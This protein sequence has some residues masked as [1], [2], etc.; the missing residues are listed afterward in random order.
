LSVLELVREF[1]AIETEL[2]V[3]QTPIEVAMDEWALGTVAH[4][5][6]RTRLRPLAGADGPPRAR[7]RRR[8]APADDLVAATERGSASPKRVSL[9]STRPGRGVQTVTWLLVACAVG[10]IALGVTAI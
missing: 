3:A 8:P 2:G 10:V 1:Q 7:R 4:L 6:D 5:E 9:S